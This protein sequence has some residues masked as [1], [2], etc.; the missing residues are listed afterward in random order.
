MSEGK[1]NKKAQDLWESHGGVI[2]KIVVATKAGV[3]DMIGCMNGRYCTLEGKLPY[4]KMSDLQI[5][6]RNK[7]IKAGGLSKEIKTLNDVLQMIK[8]ARTGY[9]QKIEST[10]PQLKS[11]SL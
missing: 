10:E 1:F 2:D 8:W 9:I 11:F 5:A 7:V 4:N 6:R 3:H